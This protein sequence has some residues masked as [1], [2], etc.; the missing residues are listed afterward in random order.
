MFP[1]TVKASDSDG[2][3]EVYFR[4]HSCGWITVVHVE[5]IPDDSD[6]GGELWRYRYFV[7]SIVSRPEHYE[8]VAE[9]ITD[10]TQ[11]PLE[12]EAETIEWGMEF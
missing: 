1:K 2:S 12:Y 6:Y 9:G 8:M 7:I 10:S 5:K 3:W 4:R 11:S